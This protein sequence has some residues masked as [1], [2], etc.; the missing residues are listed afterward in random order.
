MSL[1]D[2]KTKR[3]FTTTPEP[4]G[5]EVQATGPLRFVIHKHWASHLHYDLRLEAGGVLKSWAVPKGPS[6][7][8]ADKHLAVMVE[9]HPLDY[10]SFEGV[11]PE[12]NYGAGTVMI[13]DQ[14]T[15]CTIDT[16]DREAEEEEMRAM[17]AKGHISFILN[18]QKLHGRWNL[19]KMARSRE[20]NAWLLM[21]A[22][23]EFAT[24]DDVTQE[25]RS[26][27][28]GRTMEE[29]RDGPS[30]PD[31]LPDLSDA[32]ESP[33]PHDLSPMLAT[34]IYAAFDKP[35]WLF[36]IKWDGY[37]AIAEVSGE[38]VLLYSRNHIS[39]NDRFPSVV[40]ALSGAGL[41]A[42]F[43]GEVVVLDEQGVSQFQL[44]QRYLR[45]HES[46]LTYYVF[47][48][49][50][51][52]G[53]DLR[54]LPLTRRREILRAALPN[55]PSVKLSDSIADEGSAFFKLACDTGLE[56]IMGKLGESPYRAGVRSKEWVKMRCRL[57]QEFVVGGFTEPRGSRKNFGALALGVYDRGE[58]TYA[59]NAGSG[60]DDKSLDYIG[61]KLR[62]LGIPDPPFKNPPK[63]AMPIHWVRPE[64]VVEVEFHGWTEDNLL[65][66]PVVLGLRED[67]TAMEVFRETGVAGAEGVPGVTEGRGATGVEGVNGVTGTEGQSSL[68]PDPPTAAPSSSQPVILSSSQPAATS[69]DHPVILSSG[70]QVSLTHLTKVFWPEEGYTKGDLISYYRDV[71][72]FI[73][74]HLKDRPESMNRYPDG[75]TGQNFF[76]KNVARE[77]TPDWIETVMVGSEE[78]GH[79][80]H[81]NYLLCQD[82]AA[83]EYMANMACIELNPWSS[84]VGSLDKPDYAVLDL[85]P[86][87]VGFDEVVRTAQAARA[88]LEKAEIPS[89]PK[90]SGA[91]GIH[92]YIPLGAQYSYEH[93]RGF[94]EIL[95]RLIN[96]TIPDT[97]SV[98]RSPAR[99]HGKVYLDYL[100][101]SR[102]QTLASVYCV[103]PLPKAPVS[104]PL[105]WDEIDTLQTPTNF[106][107]RTARA[108]LDRQGDLFAPV[109][110]GGIDLAEA[111]GRLDGM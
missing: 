36:E 111:L 84:R 81:T 10:I 95:A 75:I 105:R 43:D 18:G 2:Y 29:I 102:G 108:R 7:N 69:S 56:G 50:Y 30:D 85:D 48:I 6:L 60:L 63:T 104:M 83:L 12:G 32:P 78:A 91:T 46:N 5:T 73:L 62:A 70:H 100:Q 92:V 4:T 66:Q 1:S 34:P 11:I 99:R 35:G 86:L 54:D 65:R 26:A 76:Q 39:F 57:R 14:G 8:P 3:D 59:G 107:I 82:E 72:E 93:A 110:G 31:P 38:N 22:D 79:G 96:R 41:D 13:W 80:G 58:L 28:S 25:D 106:N 23:D 27:A 21:K 53:H 109:L 67:K 64:L 74:P 103:R 87:D 45:S 15:Y 61:E 37:R 52:Q 88:L 16:C 9:D 51:L 42:V 77:S 101:N 94:V 55:L 90:T 47:D 19:V 33:M 24:T 49:L 89:Y 44:L 97:T 20:E 40:Q 98:E 68:P 71:A 17:L